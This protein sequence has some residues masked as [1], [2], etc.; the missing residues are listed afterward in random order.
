MPPG[1]S[2]P[3]RGIRVLEMAG[4][5]PAPFAC[6][7][8]ADLGADVLRIERPA[9]AEGEPAHR[10]SSRHIVT[11]RSRPALELDLKREA[12]RQRALQLVA[13]ADVLVEGF[14]PG[15]MERLGLGPDACLAANP[16]LVYGR[17]TG[18]GQDGPL[19]QVAGHDINYIALSGALH[20]I[21]PAGKPVP[22]LNLVGD[23]GGGALY[24][25]FGIA[26]ALL[27]VRRSGRGQVVDAAI[28]D[29]SL[30]LMGLVLGRWA[31]GV[32]QDE[33]G[34]NMLDGGAPWYD[35]YET[36]DGK[37]VA[38]GA[39]EPQF[40]EELRRRLGE[41]LPD[42]QQRLDRADWPALRQRLAAIFARRT[43][44]EWCALLEATDACVSP[45]LSL[46]E[47]AAHPHN[48]ARANVQALDGIVQPA[49]APRFSATPGAIQSPAGAPAEL[50][51]A[52]AARW[53]DTAP[54][55]NS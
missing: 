42:A 51:S 19:A 25:A 49:P 13:H 32:W 30:S 21:G 46:A 52:R 48:R 8:L 36:A 27:E 31:A 5:G 41:D 22:P 40:Y 16:A 50:G 47:V 2:G 11:N 29:G 20:A 35:T 54:K 17:M 33:R 24:L 6:M 38:V 10:G 1:A 18:W 23:F 55:R 15:V 34:A 9:A 45:V 26:S 14:R 44:D 28:V 12:D 3:L 43:R 4:I 7:L 53:L 37:F 39:I